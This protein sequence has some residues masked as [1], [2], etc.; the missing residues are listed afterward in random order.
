MC[1]EDE[2]WS[3]NEDWKQENQLSND[4]RCCS[5]RKT[6]TSDE[7]T[8]GCLIR[9]DHVVDRKFLLIAAA[10]V[11]WPERPVWSMYIILILSSNTIVQLD[12]TSIILLEHNW[13]EL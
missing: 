1:S 2:M 5:V 10:D 4:G 9:T 11:W 7:A 6:L 3:S 8:A 13:F 12:Y